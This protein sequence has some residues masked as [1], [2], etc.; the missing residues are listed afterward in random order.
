MGTYN[1]TDSKYTRRA[2]RTYYCTYANTVQVEQIEMN[3]Y[4]LKTIAA[5]LAPIF[6]SFPNTKKKHFIYI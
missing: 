4:L 1:E 6:Y 5:R 2:V 3:E